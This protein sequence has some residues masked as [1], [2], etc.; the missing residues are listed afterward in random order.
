MVHL[1]AWREIGR[2]SHVHGPLQQWWCKNWMH[3]NSHV[4]ALLGKFTEFNYGCKKM[5]SSSISR[6][7]RGFF[8]LSVI[9][10]WN[11]RREV[12]QRVVLLLVWKCESKQ[13]LPLP[14]ETGRQS[15][16]STSH[17][18][19]LNPAWQ[20]QSNPSTLSTQVPC[21]ASFNERV[22]MEIAGLLY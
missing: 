5:F 20:K 21:K 4:S 10:N 9:N 18:T 6:N 15:F 1:Q 22:K 2:E 11:A 8:S 3:V 17:R 14:H 12:E 19:P 13:V 7:Q 16:M